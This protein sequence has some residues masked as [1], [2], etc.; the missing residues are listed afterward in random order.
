MDD[1][2]FLTLEELYDMKRRMEDSLEEWIGDDRSFHTGD[3]G[4]QDK[5]EDISY[6]DD[7]IEKR[8]SKSNER[9]NNLMNFGQYSLKNN[10][11]NGR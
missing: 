7:E 5:L 1:L 2:D 6:V 10:K 4:Y 9:M 8:E 3:Q 11:Q